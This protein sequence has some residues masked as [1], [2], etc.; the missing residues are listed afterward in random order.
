MFVTETVTSGPINTLSNLFMDSLYLSFISHELFFSERII[1]FYETF[2]CSVKRLEYC[3]TQLPKQFLPFPVNP[4]KQRHMK[5]P[6]VL[7]HRALELQSLMSGL[8]HSSVSRSKNWKNTFL[9]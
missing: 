3:N 8:E 6:S 5:D 7:V 2:S 9:N 4:F 1:L